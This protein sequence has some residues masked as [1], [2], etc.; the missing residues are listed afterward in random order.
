MPT[1]LKLTPVFEWNWDA[2]H[3][4][5]PDTGQRK[6]RYIVNTGSSRSSKTTTLIDIADIYARK[7]KNK[8]ITVWRK[9]KANCKQTVGDDMIKHH[10]ATGRYE[11]RYTHN[12][13]ESKFIYDNGSTIEITGTDNSLK[14]HGLNQSVAWFNEPYDIV[15]AVFD[16]IDKRTTDFIIL[17]W[18]PN[19]VHFI[20]K[21]IMN[22]RTIVINSTFLDNPFCPYEQKV[23]IQSSQPVSMCDAVESGK[24]TELEARYYDCSINLLELTAKQI[25]ELLRCQHNEEI[26]T[27]NAYDWSVYGLGK[28]AEK[29]HRIF[30]WKKIE[31][32]EYLQLNAKRYYGVD[33]GKVDPWGICE[34]KYIDGCLY[35]HELNYDS[36][37]L[38]RAGLSG[39][40]KGVVNSANSGDIKEGIVTWLFNK[41]GIP[42]DAEIICDNNRP[43]KII[44]LRNAGWDY[45]MPA[46]GLKS[47]KD[48]I[49]LLN[50]LKVFY[51]STSKNV[52]AE[53]QNYSHR[54][55]RQGNVLE[56]PEDKNNH[57][58]DPTR[59]VAQ[60]LEREGIINVL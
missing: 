15:E 49:D 59:Y 5:D 43:K 40:D 28:K 48:G 21:L 19:M 10:Q 4:I 17:D 57:T 53:Q 51:T 46:D 45:A 11:N 34:Y 1:E 26:E 18:N 30:K 47:I 9:T 16:Q 44:A 3:A 23:K 22:P 52:E 12:K 35:I 20:D 42:E 7:N 24:M 55:D 27:A 36:E 60:Y 32:N 29:P 56:E 50:N 54:V 6:Y 14:V 33:W 2:I 13:T 58:I 41:L 31:V 25:K 39:Y 37:D 38:I 8:R